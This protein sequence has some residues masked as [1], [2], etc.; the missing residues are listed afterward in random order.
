MAYYVYIIYSKSLNKFYIG[1]TQDLE[2]RLKQHNAGRSRYTKPGIPWVIVYKETY[3][4]RTSAYNREKE[5]KARK[6]REYIQDLIE[7]IGY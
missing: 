3:Q 4:S 7:G 6:S 5:I 1:S 2:D